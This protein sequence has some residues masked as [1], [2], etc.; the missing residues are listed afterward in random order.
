[1]FFLDRTE[2]LYEFLGLESASF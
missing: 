2:N 1:L